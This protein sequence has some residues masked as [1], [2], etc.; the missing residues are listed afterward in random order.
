METYT[1]E[2]Y[3]KTIHQLS[4]D[5]RIKVSVSSIAEALQNRP[6]TVSVMIRK[7]TNKKLVCYDKPGGVVLSDKG[8]QLA[9]N[10]IRKHR[11][12]ETFLVRKLEFKWDEVHEIAEQLEHIHSDRLI[13]KLERF[14][15]YPERDPHGDPIPG[16]NGVIPNL[17]TIPLCDAETGGNYILKC[18]SLDSPEFLQFLDKK[19][20]KLEDE[21]TILEKERFDG[22][23]KLLLKNGQEIHLSK[24]AAEN[25][26]MG[27]SVDLST[28]R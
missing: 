1:V 27:H 23:L 2:N 13:D 9:M 7:L 25:L 22:S 10:V 16:K 8:L 28:F 20:I 11:L 4:N 19:G 17:N 12:W 14:L 3:L 15:D 18:V 6:A 21:I 5:R 24:M 26:L